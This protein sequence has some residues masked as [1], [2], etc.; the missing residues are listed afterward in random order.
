VAESLPLIG[1]LT[2]APQVGAAI[3]FVQKLFKPQIDV[4]AQNQ[5]T[6]TG[7]WDNPVI[8]KVKHASAAAKSEDEDL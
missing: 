5:Y 8:K 3:L 2:A 4:A 6:I 7:K 1:A